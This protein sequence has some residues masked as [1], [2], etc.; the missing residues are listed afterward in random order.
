MMTLDNGSSPRPNTPATA[1]VCVETIRSLVLFHVLLRLVGLKNLRHKS[2]GTWTN[3]PL[4]LK[5]IFHVIS[6]GV[7]I[8][9]HNN[10]SFSSDIA[11]KVRLALYSMNLLGAFSCVKQG[12]RKQGHSQGDGWWYPYSLLNNFDVISELSDHVAIA[13]TRGANSN[14]ENFMMRHSHL[15]VA[16]KKKAR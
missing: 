16:C 7:L 13:P 12:F 11:R 2:S 4:V 5:E 9:D 1:A 6:S 10:F 14:S 15:A 3:G 8:S